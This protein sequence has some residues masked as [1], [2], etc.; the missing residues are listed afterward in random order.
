MAQGD[1]IIGRGVRVEVGKTEG[2][3]KTVTGMTLADPCVATSVAHALTAKSV[4]YFN[5]VGGMVNIE[6]QAVR[7][8][9]VTTDTFTLGDLDTTDYPAFTS[10]SFVPITAWATLAKSTSIAE[11]GGEADKLNTTTLLD[12]IRQ[13]RNGLLA[14]ETLNIGLLAE[15]LASEALQIIR[16]A[17]RR[18]QLLVFRVTWNN[19][20]VMVFRGEPSKP[21]RDVQQ[22]QVGTG[23]IS[24][25]VK[26]FV[27]EG[28]A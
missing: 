18:S 9:A 7:L 19:G 23:S 13:E 15:S 27:T 5:N 11:G 26:G 12:N 2:T 1:L 6:G 20:D 3:A 25:T 21:G 24:V 28:A 22:G 10:G 4:G 16:R 17:A 8:A 14:A